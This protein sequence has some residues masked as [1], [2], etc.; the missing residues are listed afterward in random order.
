MGAN[1]E[2]HALDTIGRELSRLALRARNGIRHLSGD[3]FIPV[4]ASPRTSMWSRET[5]TLFRYTGVADSPVG[6]PV[7]I[8][9]SLVTRAHVFDLFPGSSL[10]EDLT[11]A[12]FTVYLVDWGVPDAA[13]SANTLETY[14]D[15]YLPDIVA[16]VL[17]DTGRDSVDV[18]GYCLGATMSAISIAGNADM[19]VASLVMLAPPID[20]SVLGVVA[21]LLGDGRLD[22][23]SLVDETG[24][25]PASVLVAAFRMAQPTTDIS[26][27]ANYWAVLPDQNLLGAHLAIL[28][29]SGTQIPF[30]GGVFRQIVTLFI[31]G[32]ALLRGVIPLEGGDVHLE[33]L[34]SRVLC[35]TGERDFLVPPESSAPLE[36]ALGDAVSVDRLSV[37]AGHAGLFVGRTARKQSVPHIID[38][39]RASRRELN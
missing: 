21:N 27:A 20:F 3:T 7:L 9:H 8:V 17:A 35:V 12:G 23:D 13:E 4:G 29:W 30:P 6:P 36:K 31:R 38:W 2:R 1:A 5:V 39:L 24:N 37:N 28:S 19:A 25:V 16:A 15:D 34:R 32:G 26:I 14:C 33:D 22:P 11:N 10:V 18:L